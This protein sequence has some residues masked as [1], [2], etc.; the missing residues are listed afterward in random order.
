M[1]E[2]VL[3]SEEV[4]AILKASQEKGQD[5]SKLVGNIDPAK[6]GEKHYTYALSNIN[7]LTRIECEKNFTSFLRKKILIQTKTFNIASAESSIPAQD[8]KNIYTSFRINPNEYYG[9]ISID[10]SFLNQ[11]L[12]LLYGGKISDKDPPI[13]TPG[14]VG[15]IV[16]EK[17][18]TLILSSLEI[19][20]KEYGQLNTEVIRTTT[21][22]NLSS[23][24]GLKPDD[25]V[26]ALELSVFFDEI[27]TIVKV[28][29]SEDFLIDVIPVRVEGNRHREKDFWRAAIKTQVVDS[30]VTI[31]VSLPNV[32]MKVRD[33]MAL[34]E[35]DVIPI[36]DPTLVYICLNNLKLFRAVAGQANN[37]LIAKILSQI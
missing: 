15:T 35:G 26:Y 22:L 36:S 12:N 6:E 4:D 3:S 14:K 21:S 31:S 23:N 33:F 27:E 13:E 32:S 2:H 34:N 17:V 20:Y 37:K 19:A 25:S 1:S 11:T 7:D 30:Q 18:A 24:I 28:L 9:V 10:M 16:A 29:I 8:S 5:L